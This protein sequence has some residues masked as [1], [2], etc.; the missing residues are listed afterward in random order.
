MLFDDNKLLFKTKTNKILG[1]VII[2]FFKEYVIF[3]LNLFAF[4]LIILWGRKR[5]EYDKIDIICIILVMNEI[6]ILLI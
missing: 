3:K 4:L 2:L 5:K 6:H 1:K